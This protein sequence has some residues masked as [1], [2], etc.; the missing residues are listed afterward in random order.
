MFNF[1]MIM[2]SVGTGAAAALPSSERMDFIEEIHERTRALIIQAIRTFY[3][4]Q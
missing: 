3:E 1:S 4:R 2:I